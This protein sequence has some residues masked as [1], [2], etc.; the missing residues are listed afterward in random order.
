LEVCFPSLFEQQAI[1]DKMK[2]IFIYRWF[3]K[4]NK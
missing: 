3:R 2:K 1:I 4:R